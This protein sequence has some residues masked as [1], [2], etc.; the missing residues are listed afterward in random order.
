MARTYVIT[1]EGSGIG[2]ALGDLLRDQG[3]RVIGVDLSG[4]EVTADLATVDGLAAMVGAVTEVSEGRI[5]AVVANAGLALAEPVTTAVNFFGAVGTVEGLRPLLAA[6]E[7]PRISVTGSMTALQPHDDDLLE[8]L[9]R[10]DRSAATARAEAMSE[11]PSTAWLNYPTSK[12]ALLRWV[13]RT[14]PTTE[15]AGS[16][17]ALN[18]VAPGVVLTP[19]TAPLLATADGR[20]MVL[21]AVPMPLNGPADPIVVARLHAFLTAPENTHLCGQCIYVD[22]GYD[23]LVRGDNTW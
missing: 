8:A 6:S 22:G 17:I 9:L 12:Q 19:M 5:D 21:D 20:K 3:H 15:Y 14:A 16:G 11:D 10:G 7:T 13:R 1:G 23:A 2:R 18:A 4:S